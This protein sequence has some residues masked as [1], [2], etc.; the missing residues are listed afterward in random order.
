MQHP[1]TDR[2]L[3]GLPGA[4]PT[5]AE[6]PTYRLTLRA[7]PARHGEPAP[8]LRLRRLLKLLLRGFGFRCVRAEEIPP[9]AA[10]EW[11]QEST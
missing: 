10:E 7:E 9:A 6:R 11:S 4:T 3:P 1:H 5:P 8:A 2:Q